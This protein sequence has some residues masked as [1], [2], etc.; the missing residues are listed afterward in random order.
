MVFLHTWVGG[1]AS[2]DGC[3]QAGGVLLNF[4]TFFF[5]VCRKCV[6]DVI[7]LDRARVLEQ[8]P[9]APEV[10]NSREFFLSSSLGEEV[11]SDVQFTVILAQLGLKMVYGDDFENF[12]TTQFQRL[13][14]RGDGAGCVGRGSCF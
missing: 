11:V 3:W 1:P 14:R 10:Q 2:A 9:P 7:D 5:F 13:D 4:F 6:E 8:F 12:C